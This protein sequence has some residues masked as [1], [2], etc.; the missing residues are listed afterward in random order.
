[1]TRCCFL[2]VGVLLTGCGGAENYSSENS[3]RYAGSYAPE[4][5]MATS[6]DLRLVTFNI[7]FG[8]HIDR[9]LQLLKERPELQNADIVLLQ[10]MDAAGVDTM[11]AG[12]QMNYV[13]YPATIHPKTKRDFGNAVLT[14]WPI[15]DDHKVILPHLGMLDGSQRIAVCATVDVREQPI[16]ACSA[17]FATPV[18]LLPGERRDQVRKVMH[19]IDGI[20]PAIIG[21][22]FNSH[23]LGKLLTEHG[24]SWP[25]KNIGDT[26][27][28]F[29][30]DQVFLRGLKATHLGKVHKNLGASDHAPVW[31]ELVPTDAG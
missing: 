28:S 10:E 14:R 9:A 24:F 17:H 21:G 29:S 15:E 23:G 30:L 6:P 26:K 5:M 31:L 3:P 7:K 13:Y 27:G 18:E 4:T 1:M 11:A 16:E 19:D 2:L 12:L 8:R 22:D 20:S 25:T